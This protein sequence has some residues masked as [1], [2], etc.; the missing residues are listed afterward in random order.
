MIGRTLSHYRV[1]EKIGAGGMGEVYRATDTRLGREVAIKVLPEEFARD[2]ERLARFEQ[3]ARLLA[4]LNHPRIAAIHGLEEADGVRFLAMELVP[5][6]T[7]AER[8]ARG[9]LA[10]DEAVGIARQI[11]EALE[12]AHEKG[13]VHRDLKPANVKVTPEGGVKVLDFGLAKAFET[14][15]SSGDQ[16]RSPTLTA[17]A[18]RAGVIMGTAAYMS[19]EQARGK[20]VD[21]RTDVWAFGCVLYE[22]LTGKVAFA[23][24]TV[25]DSIAF[26]LAREPDWKALP[27]SVTP[28][29]R[30]LLRRCLE[31]NAD[32]R[33]RD[34]GDARLE[35][36]EVLSPADAGAL[37][38]AGSAAAGE[39]AVGSRASRRWLILTAAL[40]L[41]T[42]AGHALVVWVSGRRAPLDAAPV[43]RLSILLPPETPP[44]E[45]G[46]SLWLSPDGKRLVYGAGYGRTTRLYQRM[47]DQSEVTPIVGSEGGST[48]SISPDGQFIA[49]VAD[50]KLKR[51]ALAG[52]A[53]ITLAD[54]SMSSVPAW[55]PD[56]TIIYGPLYNSGLMRISAQGGT[57][58]KVSTPDPSQG[59]LG[60]WH[61]FL[62][63]DGRSLL[64]TVWTKGGLPAARIALLDLTTGKHRILIEGGFGG[65]YVRSGHIVY[66]RPGEI[67]AAPFDAA[68]GAV[69][70]PGV[71]VVE[72]VETDP[73]S[74]APYF[75]LSDDGT[76]VYLP[77]GAAANRIVWADAT[78]VPRPITTEKRGFRFP[79]V[80][81]DGRKIAV[82]LFEQGSAD[83]WMLEPE[84][85]V[86]TRLTTSPRL[87][88]MPRFTPDGKRLVFVT[89]TGAFTLYWMPADGSAPPELLWESAFDKLPGN[90]SPDGR[91]LV[92][93][94]NEIG[95]KGDI[96]LL[97][98]APEKRA[99]PFLATEFDE[100][101]PAFS[102]DGRN[103]AFMSDES[104]Q[105][106]IYVAPAT[107]SGS[108]T[109]LSTGGG[110]DPRWAPDGRQI[111]YRNE[112]TLMA[113]ALQP[114]V[115][116][117]PGPPRTILTDPNMLEGWGG[118]PNY[119]VASDGRRFV[120]I[121]GSGTGS[122]PTPLTVVE[123]WF[124]E[125]KRRVPAGH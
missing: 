121:E 41:A 1:V 15:S 36:E 85:G 124:E 14:D 21:R 63:P 76:L 65:R 5:G 104:G 58:V 117:T 67:M 27:A 115:V 95:N 125:L 38:G 32:R 42:V 35:L 45:S 11:A 112:E 29:L 84:R 17:A 22:M 66:A 33:L 113:V 89:D 81:P 50:N 57:P 70:G 97:D 30:R 101:A 96:W 69:T 109:R 23:G 10:V 108:K 40:A 3:E 103:I 77:A 107:S 61:P 25:S 20:R 59:E 90:W 111:F 53:A 93:T 9:P 110:K 74:A 102:P 68:R 24:E 46:A 64:F 87:E 37:D 71:P 62:M 82:S 73:S 19:P 49:F 119:D 31:K 91:T 116:P 83:L 99:R 43:R 47:M 7:L 98:V 122:S 114:G 26:I 12:A 13:I 39:V 79:A 48:L 28:E 4:A 2:P 94:Q 105:M 80:S 75:S 120:V 34:L 52:G 86:L 118:Y 123:N 60:H 56:G 92:Y 16:S 100:K 18:T 55:M 88:F 106:E 54:A 78:G 8:I 6:V 44:S 72:G 51:I